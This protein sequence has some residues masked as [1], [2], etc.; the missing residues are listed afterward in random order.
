MAAR[1]V[2]ICRA[3][4]GAD[5]TAK[6]TEA[7]GLDAIVYPLFSI[8]PLTWTPPDPAAFDAV[9]LTSAN[10]PR[11]GGDAMGRYMSLPAFV[12]E[13]ATA[14][15]AEK[16][17]FQDIRICGPDVEGVISSIH[18]KGYKN[19]LHLSGHHVRP[20]DPKD[21]NIVTCAVYQAAATGEAEELAAH[22]ARA[23]VIL[24]HSPRT[25]KHVAALTTSRQRQGASIVAISEAALQAC[26]NDWKSMHAAKEPTDA[27]M[28]AL[29]R[30][31]CHT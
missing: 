10:A 24:V 19:I 5:A 20:Y 3:Q 31:I 18:N 16:A 28:L 15:A 22:L 14:K 2:L 11:H 13:E 29:V 4:P 1:P 27:A 25:G 30:Q 9:M 23:P 8:E 7:L 17:G 6:R 21:L 12:V 26:G